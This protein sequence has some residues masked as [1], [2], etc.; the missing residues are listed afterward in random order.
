M[1]VIATLASTCGC[2]AREDI[3]NVKFAIV[4]Q[5]HVKFDRSNQSVDF[6]VKNQSS[7]TWIIEDFKVCEKN[8]DDKFE[9]A[10]DLIYQGPGGPKP[11][12][13]HA[14]RIIPYV[15]MLERKEDIR[16]PVLQEELNPF[17]GGERLLE[18][19]IIVEP[20]MEIQKHI[21]L[22]M[23]CFTQRIDFVQ[24]FLIHEGKIVAVLPKIPVSA[25]LERYRWHPE[26]K[27]AREM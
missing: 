2:I 8:P 21:T 13:D 14:Q 16:T 24:I 6:V 9:K 18:K 11:P 17:M 5:S 26:K 7:K 27:R 3:D 19:D 1:F 20:G 4:N 22:P 25:D 15:V 23:D 10:S 12:E